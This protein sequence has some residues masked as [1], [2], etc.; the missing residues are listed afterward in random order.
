[1]SLLKFRFKR[2]GILVVSVMLKTTLI[3]TIAAPPSAEEILAIPASVDWIEVRA[4][5]T[6]EIEANWL[7]QRFP[8]GLLYS[9]EAT[10]TNGMFE[11][12]LDERNTRLTNAAQGYDLIVL[13]GNLDLR[14]ELLEVI[15][16]HKRL[17]RTHI[18]Q[19]GGLSIQQEFGRISDIEARLY[20]L[21]TSAER[22]SET[23]MPLRFLNSLGRSDVW[24]AS[25]GDIGYWTRLVAP[26]YGAPLVFGLA[27]QRPRSMA[28][29]PG[30]QQLIDD[31]GL[32][33]LEAATTIY[34]IVGNPVRHSLSP[35]L[36]NTAY[37]AAGYPA[38]FLP[39]HVDVFDEFWSEFV[40]GDAFRSLGL[41][42]GGLTVASPHKEAALQKGT[43]ASEM[44]RRASSSN[45]MI[46]SGSHWIADTT[47][48]QGVVLALA[49]LDTDLRRKPAAVVGCGGAGRAI[50]AALDIAGADVTLVNR[51]PERGTWASGLLGLPFVQLADFEPG[52]FEII[53]NATPVG[54]GDGQSPFPADRTN[55]AAII[56]DLVYAEEPTPLVDDALGLGRQ[57]IDGRE[58][59]LI[60]VRRQFQLMTGSEMPEELAREALACESPVAC[61]AA[62]Q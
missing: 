42:M 35:R 2:I 43:S 39:F 26:Q 62:G 33:E 7:R 6:G 8:G 29:E 27:G 57:V 48:P 30:I 41:A 19:A 45:L 46:P 32:P 21:T 37:R 44:A 51:S 58:V 14:L 59:L 24:A 28:A 15:P 4:D 34:G 52:D 20:M 22:L 12:S 60:Q 53:V 55:D 49:E 47:D 25:S 56:V 9:L 61:L 5:L 23:L 38:L 40:V 50:A 10:A 11:G 54:R 36:H 16:P 17:I 3:A 31:Y 18:S 13:D 1:M